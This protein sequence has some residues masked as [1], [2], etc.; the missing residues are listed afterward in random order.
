MPMVCAVG[1]RLFRPGRPVRR[2][3][4]RWRRSRDGPDR[5]DARGVRER[6]CAEVLPSGSHDGCGRRPG[7]GAPLPA[8]PAAQ[9][10]RG[11][12]TRPGFARQPDLVRRRSPTATT[13]SRC[14][15]PTSPTSTGSP[16]SSSA[17]G[18]AWSTPTTSA[19]ARAVGGWPYHAGAP[20]DSSPSVAPINANGHRHRLRRHAAT[21]RNPTVGGYQAIAT[22]R[23]RPVV[24]PGGQPR[25]RPHARTRPCR[26]R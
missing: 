21:R 8:A 15:R 11:R 1:R 6:S 25:H 14:P 13:R 24:R 17:T 9:A 16:P 26:P 2:P 19:T 7:S 12:R 22:Q 10:D 18:P 4:H 5:A 23:R 20:V 3:G